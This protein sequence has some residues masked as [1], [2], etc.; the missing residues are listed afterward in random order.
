MTL[1]AESEYIPL[2][3]EVLS[4]KTT[5]HTLKKVHSPGSDGTHL[6]GKQRQVDVSLR[7]AWS[8]DFQDSY[9]YSYKKKP[10]LGEKKKV[11]STPA[12]GSVLG[13]NGR[14]AQHRVH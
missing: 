5:E 13:H 2:N 9:G 10:C 3:S 6:V 14:Q 12:T 1:Q 7:P 11:H 4:T 8:T